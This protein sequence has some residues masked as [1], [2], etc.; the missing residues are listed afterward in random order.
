M[1]ATGFVRRGK[2]LHRHHQGL[3]QLLRIQKKFDNAELALLY[4]LSVP[5]IAINLSLARENVG[6]I[7]VFT[8]SEAPARADP[9][10]IL[11]TRIERPV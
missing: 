2:L 11:R 5:Y 8:V 6:K 3:P 4:F 7:F 9:R 1:S 10:R